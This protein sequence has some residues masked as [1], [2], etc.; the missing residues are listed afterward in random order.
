MTTKIS[1]ESIS[2]KASAVS[3]SSSIHH[4]VA[5]SATDTKSASTTAAGVNRKTIIDETLLPPDEAEKIL[6]R[7]AYNRDCATRARKRSKQ[8]VSQLEK[9]VK[10]LQEDKEALRR[11]LA[12][13][14]KQMVE[15][16]SQNKAL[17]LKQ[18]LATNR[19]G[20]GMMTDPLAVGS[21]MGSGLPTS[22]M[23]QLSQQQQLQLRQLRQQ[24]AMGVGGAGGVDLAQLS[25]YMNG[26][27]GYF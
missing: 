1:D 11:S 6:A 8:M 5:S 26:Q 19:A 13:M 15:L 24:A 17:K 4:D 2:T 9:Q 23:L 7:R 14:E 10:E 18:M 22:S 3:A 20:G 12:T 16:E 25:R 21:A 27:N